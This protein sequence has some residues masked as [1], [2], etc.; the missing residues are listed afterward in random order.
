MTGVPQVEMLWESADPKVVLR[1]RFGLPGGDAA[2]RWVARVLDQHYGTAMH[3][4]ER[5][6]LSDM[7]ALAWVTTDQGPLLVKWCVARDR[8]ARLKGLADLTA[9]LAERELPVSALVPS[10]EGHFQLEVGGISVGVQRVIDA[11]LLDV[12]DEQ[13]VW[14]AGVTLARLHESLAAY[15]VGAQPAAWSKPSPSLRDQVGG[16]LDTA[17]AHQPTTVIAELRRRL[18]A[19]PDDDLPVQLVHGDYRSANILCRD[20]EVRAVLDF[21]EARLEQ[22]VADLA[23]SAVLLGTRFHNWGPVSRRTHHA[24]RAGY[25]SVRPL[26]AV[27]SAWWDV[28]TLWVTAMFIPEGADP[29]GWSDAAMALAAAAGR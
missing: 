9:W 19:A 23:R 13:E 4:C 12:A 29:T 17:P 16:W 27:E 15:P 3:R 7:N 11:E 6:V 20:R 28:M 22:P 24:V 1:D 21:E 5:V 10:G 2:A 26:T 14:H 25:E 8:F 18:E